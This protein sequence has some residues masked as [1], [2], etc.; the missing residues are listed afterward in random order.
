MLPQQKWTTFATPSFPIGN[1]PLGVF[2]EHAEL[3]FG[4][5]LGGS[6]CVCG[7]DVA[8]DY[9]LGCEAGED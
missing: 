9:F 5:E 8:W 6:F 3:E 1:Q 4:E 2:E 7:L